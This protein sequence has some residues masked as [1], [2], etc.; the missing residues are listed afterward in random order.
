MTSEPEPMATN[1]TERRRWNDPRWIAIWVRRERFTSSVTE[2]LLAHLAPA[3]GERIV[4]IGSGGGRA[5]MTIAAGVGTGGGAVGA[6]LSAPLC[7]LASERARR[8]GVDNATFVVADAQQDAIAGAPFDAA[9]SQFGVMFFDEPE[10]AFANVRR[11]VAPGGRL[12]FACWQAKDANPWFAGDALS[13]FVPAPPAP[14]A[15][16][17]PPARPTGPFS[18]ADPEETARILAAAGWNGIDCHPYE[19][20]ITTALDEIAD[21]AQ[22]AVQGVTGDQ[23]DAAWAALETA[24]APL[25]RPDGRYDAPLAFQI[26]TA[27]A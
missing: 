21:R 14:P 5:T 13:P 1:E 16:T 7:E 6:D 10:R 3:D 12:V 23:L 4:D 2:H 15:P 18:L 27:R 11:H 24:I 8:A 20:V 17:G 25:A 26:F 19:L 22:L 9:A